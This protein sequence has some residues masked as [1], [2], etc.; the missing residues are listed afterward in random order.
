V[1]PSHDQIAAALVGIADLPAGFQE[2]PVITRD[3]TWAD[4]ACDAADE[5]FLDIQAAV[6]ADALAE[7]SLMRPT[8]FWEVHQSIMVLEDPDAWVGAAAEADRACN[9][10]R[11]GTTDGAG[12]YEFIEAGVVPPGA[13]GG[14]SGFASIRWDAGATQ[15]VTVYYLIAGN[16]GSVITIS[17]FAAPF[18]P[19]V[20]DLDAFI[21]T[22]AA[23]LA[24]VDAMQPA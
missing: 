23:R 17:S 22:L 14:R 2:A 9:G 15:S 4:P 6:P 20:A 5:A 19:L 8:D 16:L 12:V 13:D 24:S 11:F 1:K 10:V 18:T 7:R 3:V 21:A